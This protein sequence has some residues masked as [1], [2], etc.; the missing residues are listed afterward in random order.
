M[1]RD[2]VSVLMG[3]VPGVALAMVITVGLNR[4]SN[5]VSLGKRRAIIISSS[6]LPVLVGT[7]YAFAYSGPSAFSVLLLAP[8][9]FA[10]PFGILIVATLI[11][12]V[13][14][15]LVFSRRAVECEPDSNVFE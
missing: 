13:P 11:L 2:L 1:I 12:S 3:T 6:L 10:V 4:L 14:L 15:A 5:S 7:L 9:E 8:V